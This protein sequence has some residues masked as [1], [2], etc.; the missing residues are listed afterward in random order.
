MMTHE[1]FLLKKK[2]KQIIALTVIA[3]VLAAG[4]VGVLALYN[5]NQATI[6]EQQ[7]T[8]DKLNGQIAL[9]QVN[10]TDVTPYV[11]QIASLKTQLENLNYSLSDVYSELDSY[12]QIA[13]LQK[14]GYLYNEQTL[15]QN[16]NS[17]MTLWEGTV[18]YAGYILVTATSNADTT[19]AQVTYTFSDTD[20]NFNQT[21]GTSGTAVFPVLPTAQ[22]T[23][24]I[25]SIGNAQTDLTNV[26][27]TVS[28]SFYY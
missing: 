23:K 6:D 15:T 3:I 13:L 18:G 19:Y 5:P 10:Q 11:S 22:D 14:T 9:F 12:M 2:N 8:I 26:T 24:L 1:T 16:A 20:F 27:T 21:I 25:V 17:S 7:A 28:A 4:L